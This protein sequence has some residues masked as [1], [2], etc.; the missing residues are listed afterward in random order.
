MLETPWEYFILTLRYR[1]KCWHGDTW[2]TFRYALRLF[3]KFFSTINDLKNCMYMLCTHRISQPLEFEY[4][5]PNLWVFLRKLKDE[6]KRCRQ[7]LH[8]VA[9]GEQPPRRKRCYRLL[10]KRLRTL[11]RE[12]SS[13]ARSFDEYWAAVSYSIQSFRHWCELS[14]GYTC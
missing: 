5:G 8:S 10:Q 2:I 7:T 13:G 14:L 4:K 12:Y 1:P 6:E 9:R 11:R 3:L